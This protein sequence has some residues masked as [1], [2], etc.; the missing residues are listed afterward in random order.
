[1]FWYPYTGS[2]PHGLTWSAGLFTTGLAIATLIGLA[3]V[4]MLALRPAPSEPVA[5]PFDP[6]TADDEPEVKQHAA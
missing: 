6:A 1:M 3:R 2:V 5:V 4:A